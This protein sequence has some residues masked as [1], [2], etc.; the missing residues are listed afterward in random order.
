MRKQVLLLFLLASSW[1]KAQ[2]IIVPSHINFADQHFTLHESGRQNLQDKVNSLLKYPKYFQLKVDLADTYFPIIER[3]FREEGLPDDFKYLA[4]IESGLIQDAVSTSNA[5]GFWQFKKDTA[6]DYGLKINQDVDERKHITASSRSAAR[7]LVKSNT[8]YYKNWHNTILS[9]YHGFTGAKALARPDHINKKEME[10][11][12]RTDN[13][14]LKLLAHK[15]AYG[16]VVGKNPTPL[17][18]LREVPVSGK[19]I[20]DIALENQVAE[21]EIK[22]YN[23]WL[24]SQYI[25][26]DKTYT[27]LIP[28]INPDQ[29]MI[30]A[31]QRTS[32]PT[33]VETAEIPAV[34][35]ERKGKRQIK[36]LNG[37]KVIV[38]KN[39]DTKED[40]A[41]QAHL[42]T[43]RFLSINE[44]RNSDPIVEGEAYYVERKKSKASVQYHVV[45]E[46]EQVP[47]IAQRYGIKAHSILWYNRLKHREVLAAGRL[48]W[49]QQRRPANVPVEYRNTPESEPRQERA[50]PVILAKDKTREERSTEN[51]T[52]S[53][54]K[55]AQTK[56]PV[57]EYP[58]R[59]LPEPTPTTPQP[60]APETVAQ[61]EV[62]VNTNVAV[63]TNENPVVTATAPAPAETA[64]KEIVAIALDSAL[65]NTN[66][67]GD[68]SEEAL[69]ENVD[70]EI[71]TINT[72]PVP[73]VVYT[74]PEATV[75]VAT[76]T[77][78]VSEKPAAWTPADSINN[79]KEKP[80]VILR[81]PTDAPT[82]TPA[83][84]V[85]KEPS[86]AVKKTP[87]PKETVKESW[88]PTVIPSSHVVVKGETLYSI[89]KQYGITIDDL[90]TWNNLGE[91]PLAIGQNLQVAAPAY[92]TAAAPA[93]T[94][95]LEDEPVKTAATP[96]VGTSTSHTVQAGESMYQIS[97]KY[98]VTIKDIMD[99]NGK[100]D[101]NVKPGERLV[102]KTVGNSRY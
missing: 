78:A 42:S 45:K 7:Y 4:L 27:V 86:V 19:N 48:L 36:K 21:D 37:L 60:A 98:G 71:E 26:N 24:A 85:L 6:T 17:V 50:N 14:I 102:I 47:Q 95:M 64:E 99:W 9:Y 33:V 5:V 92:Q 32:A 11:T 20:S 41:R 63:I 46:G 75:K 51:K 13:Y 30:L 29:R 61:T 34:K 100:S 89:S 70:A 79:T 69:T 16:T 84:V 49:L 90:K 35:T 87:A 25:P 54:Q 40:L 62:A 53:N 101:F 67:V 59:K 23:K 72:T 74:K 31:S 91:M 82:K 10:I 2:A 52:A 58:T 96:R 65:A 94:A 83:K 77:D 38:A 1:A 44:M 43:R 3:V 68:T 93:S 80:V 28:V 15:I 12:D 88:S 39:G 56:Q 73:A 57:K 97:R 8:L 81:E 55:P 66:E 18:M 76:A 22:Q